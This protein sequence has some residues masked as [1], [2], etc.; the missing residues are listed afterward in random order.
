MGRQRR[1]R[2]RGIQRTLIGV[3]NVRKEM[4]QRTGW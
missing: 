3:E 2:K 1:K 4:M